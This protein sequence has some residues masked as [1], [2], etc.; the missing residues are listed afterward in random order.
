MALLSDSV[1]C[2]EKTWGS[3]ITQKYHTIGRT[4]ARRG[5]CVYIGPA[6][7][8]SGLPE[9]SN[10]ELGE[11]SPNAQ[12]MC[13]SYATSTPTRPPPP[14]EIWF[15]SCSVFSFG[16]AAHTVALKA[17]FYTSFGASIQAN[18][19]VVL[20]PEVLPPQYP[21]PS[22]TPSLGAISPLLLHC[23]LWKTWVCAGYLCKLPIFIQHACSMGRSVF[24]T[25]TA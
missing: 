21:T 5:A 6:H 14:G 3:F 7:I 2:R 8:R 17:D 24:T 16:D 9:S 13:A 25:K 23:I 19:T 12:R 10:S 4:A 1:D 20:A 15:K 22:T 11:P 18:F